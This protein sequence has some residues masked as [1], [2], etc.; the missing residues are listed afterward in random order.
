MLKG[1]NAA[2]NGTR[3]NKS[4][5]SIAPHYKSLVQSASFRKTEAQINA[6]LLSM[7]APVS[8]PV[9]LDADQ[10]K[11]LKQ[12]SSSLKTAFPSFKKAAFEEV[13]MQAWSNISKTLPASEQMG[14]V[15]PSSQT[16]VER[17]SSR[18]TTYILD[19]FAVVSLLAGILIIYMVFLQ[20]N[21]LTPVMTDTSINELFQKALKSESAEGLSFFIYLFKVITSCGT[22][23]ISEAATRIQTQINTFVAAA[24]AD[25]SKTILTTCYTANTGVYGLLET[26][27][28]HYSGAGSQCA[29]QTT[30]NYSQ[31]LLYNA[32]HSVAL[33]TIQATKMSSMLTTGLRLTGGSIG[34]LV[35]RTTG[36]LIPI[37]G[38]SQ[39]DVTKSRPKSRGGQRQRGGP[40]GKT[41]KNK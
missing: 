21:S 20:L 17:G 41:R 8:Q 36:K 24:I 37:L 19:F 38:C 33:F 25:Y 6:L 32:Q 31:L 39:K 22:S 16:L 35:Y 34:Y 7:M 4:V 2:F 23:V 27:A 1:L 9:A 18:T 28:S 3:K 11:I 13:V 30:S 15:S 5:S 40:K 29:L 26:A 14:G 10:K 12:V